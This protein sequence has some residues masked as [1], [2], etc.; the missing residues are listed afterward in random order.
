[1]VGPRFG[2]RSLLVLLFLIS[3]VLPTGCT[4]GSGSHDVD[5]AA[6]DSSSTSETLAEVPPTEDAA[7]DVAVDI[8]PDDLRDFTVMTFN[9]LCSFCNTNYDPWEVRLDYFTDIFKRY[10]PDLIGLQEFFSGDEVQQVLDRNPGYQALFFVDPGGGALPNYPDATIFSRESRF[11]VLEH[12]FYWLSETP[13]KVWS[14]GWADTNLWRLV[15]WAHLKQTEDGRELYFSNTHFDNN[16]PNQEMSA[17]LFVD[18]LSSW[19]KEMPVIAVGDFNSKPDTV[20]YATLTAETNGVKL[21]NSFDL[22]QTWS[23]I[24]NQPEEPAYEPDHRIDHI[25]LAGL[26]DWVI[27]DWW[28][29][30]YTY[31]PENKYPSDHFA[32]AT[33]VQLV[34]K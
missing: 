19:A 21:L 4:T 18:R 29:D 30:L 17:P 10:D 22:A 20:A 23:V 28:V 13:D 5:V 34:P 25:F 31:G 11:E 33:K 26:A 24:H 6:S 27:S 14:G 8:R 15:A 12:G 2:A 16:P 32:I 7:P 3:L 9:V 1:M